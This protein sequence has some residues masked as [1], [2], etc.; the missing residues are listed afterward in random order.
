MGTV[1]GG[2]KKI[3]RLNKAKRWTGFSTDTASDGIGLA[4]QA[5]DVYD[6]HDA[7][8]Q[9]MNKGF[10]YLNGGKKKKINRLKKAEK[11]RDFSV[12]TVS[13]GIGLG[14]KAWT[15]YDKHDAKTQAINK[16]FE[17]TDKLFGKGTMTA[18]DK[19]LKTAMNR[20]VKFSEGTMTKPTKDQIALLEK[21]GVLEAEVS[22]GCAVK[23]SSVKKTAVGGAVKKP[24]ARA[25]IVKKVMAQR[26]IGLIEASKVVKAEGLY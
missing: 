22:G 7:K 3:N 9:A 25:Q 8:K 18:H 23:K 12:G 26:G 17:Q 11:W 21:A 24:N 2:K 15:V 20:L 5:W 1:V 4:D 6:K 19:K 14:D 13:D 10:S 16:G